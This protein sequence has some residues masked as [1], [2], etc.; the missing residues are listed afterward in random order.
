MSY[1][2]RYLPASLPLSLIPFLINLDYWRA[3]GGL[4]L[5][6]AISQGFGLTVAIVIWLLY[7]A[8]FAALTR[9]RTGRTFQLPM[10]FFLVCNGFGMTLGIWVALQLK[11]LVL[12]EPLEI[13]LFLPSLAF[14]GLI[15]LLF[16]F[17]FAYRQA[18]EEALAMRAA[19][20]EAR[21]Q[22][23]EH[24]MRPHF[25]FNAL[26]SLA[27]LIESGEERAAEM[28]Y[29]LSELYRQILAHS[30]L[31]TAPL[32]AEAEIARRYL[33][34][35]QVRF[36]RRLTFSINIPDQAERIYLPSLMLQTLVENA[37]KHGVSKSVDG[38]H[39]AVEVR[40]MLRGSYELSVTN[41]GEWYE[42]NGSSGTGLA[43]TRARL[44]LLYGSSHNFCLQSDETGRT[45]A[46]FSF[47][48]EK[49]D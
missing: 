13:G 46:S 31:K 29:T 17:H 30:G 41:T 19:A 35:E 27:E 8:V 39:I 26:N 20:A 21:Y 18:R 14:G 33:E 40:Q 28:T 32:G 48:G 12:K 45:V 37:V 4:W 11:A 15:L 5:G 2:L 49:I 1:Y 38:G 34:L 43:N 23:L 6:L 36:G 42:R 22:A 25:L 44:D 3:R 7:A 16:F 47:S 9:I 24:Q 10:I